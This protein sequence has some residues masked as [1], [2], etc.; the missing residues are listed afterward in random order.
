LQQLVVLVTLQEDCKEARA[1]IGWWGEVLQQEQ[2]G[3][4]H[5]VA[6]RGCWV[7]EQQEEEEG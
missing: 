6:G 3:G 7:V 1:V 4:Q 2:E 5:L